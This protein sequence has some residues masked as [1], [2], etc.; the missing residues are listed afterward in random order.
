MGTI[1]IPFSKWSR[2]GVEDKDLVIKELSA[3]LKHMDFSGHA[4]RKKGYDIEVLLP[5]EGAV[6][7]FL[8]AWRAVVVELDRRG[9]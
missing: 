4:R 1:G 6:E 3:A 2:V 7:R 5:D 8:Q 9:N